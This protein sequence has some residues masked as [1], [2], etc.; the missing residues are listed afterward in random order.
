MF[1]SGFNCLHFLEICFNVNR[2]RITYFYSS[3]LAVGNTETILLTLASYFTSVILKWLR[4]STFLRAT[5][6]FMQIVKDMRKIRSTS[7]ASF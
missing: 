7:V 2:K 6:P 5:E 3:F 1:Y 4:A